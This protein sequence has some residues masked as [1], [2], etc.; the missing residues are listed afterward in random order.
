LDGHWASYVL[1]YLLPFTPALDY[2]DGKAKDKYIPHRI[3][4]FLI[5]SI[6]LVL[7][8]MNRKKRN[9]L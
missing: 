3:E 6:P 2:N 7:D 8:E 1:I 5:V 4:P 9:F